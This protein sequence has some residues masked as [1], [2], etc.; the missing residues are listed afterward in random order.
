MN[1]VAWGRTTV[2]TASMSHKALNMQFYQNSDRFQSLKS[3]AN[4]LVIGG[5]VRPRTTT[6]CRVQV[7]SVSSLPECIQRC[8]K[9][10]TTSRAIPTAYLDVAKRDWNLLPDQERPDSSSR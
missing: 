6:S 10:L 2:V 3:F 7:I 8:A 9:P 1:H 4:D 5:T